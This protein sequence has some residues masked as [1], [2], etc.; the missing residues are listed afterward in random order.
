[1]LKLNILCTRFE[2]H[3][4]NNTCIN[5]GNIYD[6]SGGIQEKRKKGWTHYELNLPKKLIVFKVSP[7]IE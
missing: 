1:M 6:N 5:N 3:Y 7:F 2:S 4:N